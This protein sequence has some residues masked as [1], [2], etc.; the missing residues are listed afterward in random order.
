MKIYLA[1]SLFNFML[2]GTASA[3]VTY[4]S[5]TT[6]NGDFEA[7]V[8]GTATSKFNIS[9]NN[10]I[11]WTNWTEFDTASNDTGVTAAPD[12]RL[13]IQPGG[14]V[15]SSLTTATGDGSGAGIVLTYGFDYEGAGG[16]GTMVLLWSNAG[17]WTEIPNSFLRSGSAA[18]GTAG[19]YSRNFTVNAGDAWAGQAI[20]V[21]F[22]N[23]LASDG[24]ALPSG[25]YPN[26]DNVVFSSI[27]EPS[28]ALLG[29]LGA[30]VLLRR[31][32]C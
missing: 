28:A 17:V 13:Y 22:R 27:P 8:S 19:T 9:T 30:L 3:A 23:A 20:T 1:F 25:Q 11:N 29:G 21:A 26:I 14:A 4:I 32:R 10:S 6:G 18:G 24:G 5:G 31:R 16:N 12:R 15:R 2:L 7:V